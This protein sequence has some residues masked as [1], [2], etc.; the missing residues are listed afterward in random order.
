MTD[1]ITENYADNAILESL[2]ISVGRLIMQFKRLDRSPQKF[3]SAG[4]LTLSEIHTI[5]AIGCESGILMGELAARLDITKGAVTQMIKRL[6][7]KDLVCRIPHP[8]DFRY[9]IVSLTKNGLLAY[10]AHAELDQELYRKLSAELT[11]QEMETFRTCLEK[12]CE[13]LNR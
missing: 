9:T 4:T 12:F 1:K 13:V 8:T 11:A 10:Q 3:G 7:R 5:D 6:E 2:S